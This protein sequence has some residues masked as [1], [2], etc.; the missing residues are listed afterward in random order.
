MTYAHKESQDASHDDN[1]KMDP[2]QDDYKL[3][4]IKN[5]DATKDDDVNLFIILLPYNFLYF[6]I[7]QK[8]NNDVSML[9]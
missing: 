3:E 7:M 4:S 2:D 9:P 5:T 8:A 6:Y 1:E